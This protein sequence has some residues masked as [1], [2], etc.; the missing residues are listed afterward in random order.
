MPVHVR[1]CR[2]LFHRFDKDNS[3]GLDREEFRQ[4]MLE[5]GVV[6]SKQELTEVMR[7]FSSSANDQI[8]SAQVKTVIAF[9]TV[10]GEFESL[11]R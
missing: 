1:T 7:E 8:I 4:A 6:M 9:C 10:T 2:Y 5:L 11:V 3:G